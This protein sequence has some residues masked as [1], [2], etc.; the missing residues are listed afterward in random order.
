MRTISGLPQQSY[1]SKPMKF[2]LRQDLPP[3]RL[4][5]RMSTQKRVPSAGSMSAASSGTDFCCGRLAHWTVAFDKKEPR[6]HTTRNPDKRSNL[7]RRRIC[8][9]PESSE[10]VDKFEDVHIFYHRGAG[11]PYRRKKRSGEKEKSSGFVLGLRVL[12]YSEGVVGGIRLSFAW[13]K[14]EKYAESNGANGR[15]QSERCPHRVHRPLNRQFT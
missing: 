14:A 9:T 15:P 8:H 10:R 6:N 11:C 13:S 2:V 3:S 5:R 1:M 12:S 7:A 4:Q